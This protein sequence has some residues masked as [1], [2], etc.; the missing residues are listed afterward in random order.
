MSVAAW[1]RRFPEQ[2]PRRAAAVAMLSTGLGDLVTVSDIV[3]SRT[4][5]P[6]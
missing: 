2:V 3:G 1:A 5:C 4:G 6:W